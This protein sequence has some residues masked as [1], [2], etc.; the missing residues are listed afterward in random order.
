MV[1]Q[2]PNRVNQDIFPELATPPPTYLAY[3]EW[4]TPLTATPDPKHRMFRVARLIRNKQRCAE[5]VPVDSFVSS[6]HLLPRFGP[7]THREWSSFTVL[8]Q[9]QSFYVNPF[10]DLRN[11]LT[12]A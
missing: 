3:V 7:L 8:E 5:I 12:F 4:F 1:F 10:T 9:C 11:Y 2:I 6:I